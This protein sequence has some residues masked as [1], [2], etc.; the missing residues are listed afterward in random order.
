MSLLSRWALLNHDKFIRLLLNTKGLMVHHL[1]IYENKK[2]IDK[3]GRTTTD[4]QTSI[5]QRWGH[6]TLNPRIWVRF[7]VGVFFCSLLLLTKYPQ[8]SYI[9]YQV[10]NDGSNKGTIPTTPIII[11]MKQKKGEKM[12]FF[13]HIFCEIVVDKASNEL[14]Y[15]V[16]AIC[17]FWRLRRGKFEYNKNN[18]VSLKNRESKTK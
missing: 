12:E 18:G 3:V 4:E 7:P 13:D 8:F 11:R 10:Q 2:P 17:N 1:N 5:V 14:L 16:L 15:T 9:Q 6:R